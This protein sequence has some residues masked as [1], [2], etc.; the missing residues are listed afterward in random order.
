MAALMLLG[1]DLIFWTAIGIVAI[2]M[3]LSSAA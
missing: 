1:F 2:S 3:A